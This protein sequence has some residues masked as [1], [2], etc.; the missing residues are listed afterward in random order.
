MP[1]LTTAA[2]VSSRVVTVLMVLQGGQ[3]YSADGFI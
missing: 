2:T 1:M 3:G